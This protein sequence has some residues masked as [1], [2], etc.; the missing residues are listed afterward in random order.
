MDKSAALPILESLA[1][2]VRL[3][4]YRLL[5]REGTAGLVAGEIAAA[6]AVA[7]NNLSFHLRDM[8]QAGLLTSQ[9]EGRFQR[10]RANLPAMLDLLAFLTEECC[11]G[12]PELCSGLPVAGARRRKQAAARSGSQA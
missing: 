1:S 10:Y 8:T 9:Q 6:L 3:D 2:P 7:P 5:V 11:A 4:V 12:Q